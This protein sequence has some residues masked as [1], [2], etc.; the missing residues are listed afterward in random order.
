MTNLIGDLDVDSYKLSHYLQYPPG[1]TNISSYVEPRS[2]P[3]EIVFFGLQAWIKNTLSH[4][5][6]EEDV[7]ELK[8]YACSHGLP[9]NDKF[10]DLCYK[11][12]PLRIQALPEGTIVQPGTC[13]VQVTNTDPKYPWLTSFVETSLLRAVWYPTTVATKSRQIKKIIKHYLEKTA[14]NADGLPFKLHDFGFRGVSSHESGCIGGLAHLVN[15]QGTDTMGALRWARRY[16]HEPMAGFSIPA[17]EHSTMTSWGRDRETEA[18]A[19]MIDKFGG[20]GIFAVVSDSYDIYNACESIWGG[21]LRDQVKTNG[22]TLVVRPDSGDPQIVILK[23]LDILGDKF[24]TRT[25]TKGF[26]MLPDYLRIIQGDGVNELSIHTILSKMAVHGWSSDNIAFGMGGALLQDVTRDDFSFAMKASAKSN[27]NGTTWTG[28][29]KDPVTMTSKRSKAGR[30]A[31]I[32]SVSRRLITIEERHLMS[33]DCNELRDVWV[34]GKLLVDD[35]LS[36]IR[37]RAE[38]K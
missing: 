4:F 35:T 27:D 37:N 1:L 6:H 11:P 2:G 32:D 25:N 36:D 7:D 30:L 10:Y 33:R 12:L 3:D 38:V 17:A 15:F 14:D 22:G 34:N 31:V 5:A 24:G 9:F 28:F 8:D 19:N 16:Y 13:L 20:P 23:I 26:R 29:A 18:Y 21:S